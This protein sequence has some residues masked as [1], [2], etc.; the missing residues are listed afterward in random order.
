VRTADF[1]RVRTVTLPSLQERS[2]LTNQTEQVWFAC[3]EVGS[4]PG[5]HP[6]RDLLPEGELWLA[7]R[8]PDR[9][10]TRCL[11]L[12]RC[13]VYLNGTSQPRPYYTR[14]GVLRWTSHFVLKQR[15]Q[16]AEA[17]RREREEERR[18]QEAFWDS[19]LGKLKRAEAELRRLE[20]QGRVPELP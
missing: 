8:T 1:A 13:S 18:E 19:P 4:L 2:P 16:D 3:G 17:A 6:L 10:A 7:D 5:G 11:I 20:Q 9:L 15:E 14:A 12:G